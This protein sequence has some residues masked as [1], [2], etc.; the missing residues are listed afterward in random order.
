MRCSFIGENKTIASIRMKSNYYITKLH[1]L[2]ISCS[3]FQLSFASMA[4]DILSF[5]ILWTLPPGTKTLP[6]DDGKDD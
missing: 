5:S 3:S 1:I 6:S 2:H 4:S